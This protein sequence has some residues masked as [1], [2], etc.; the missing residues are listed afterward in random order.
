MSIEEKLTALGEA[1]E[2]SIDGRGRVGK[3]FVAGLAISTVVPGDGVAAWE[4]AVCVQGGAWHPVQRYET[5]EQAEQGHAEWV[6][7]A[8]ELDRNR[9][10]YSFV[11][12][13]AVRGVAQGRSL[14]AVPQLG[15]VWQRT[16]VLGDYRFRVG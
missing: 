4:T 12:S 9:S 14:M 6:A 15:S 8:P 13:R 2:A 7:R 5:R 1:V 10:R 11:W 16:Q 3:Q